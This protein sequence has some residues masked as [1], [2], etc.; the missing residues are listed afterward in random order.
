MSRTER[1]QGA[2]LSNIRVED[3][4][5]YMDPAG[6]G[7]HACDDQFRIHGVRHARG[8]LADTACPAGKHR[9]GRC[10][11]DQSTGGGADDTTGGDGDGGDPATPIDIG[12]VETSSVFLAGPGAPDMDSA[13]VVSLFMTNTSALNGVLVGATV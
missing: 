9:T 8:Q 1:Y 2:T 7:H 4:V 13:D 3:G 12:E 11:V 10:C 5:G 6:C